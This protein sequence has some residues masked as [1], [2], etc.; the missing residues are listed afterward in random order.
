M[1]TNPTESIKIDASSDI[2]IFSNE[3]DKEGLKFY[4]ENKKIKQKFTFKAHS[5]TE[6]DEWTQCLKARVKDAQ[7]E[8]MNDPAPKQEETKDAESKENDDGGDDE[9]ARAY[10]S[11][12]NDK[13]RLPQY[14]QIF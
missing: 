7:S 12:F 3:E 5:T 4:I 13:L 14:Y 9:I 8:V 11:W 2:G 10:K 1:Y 6:R